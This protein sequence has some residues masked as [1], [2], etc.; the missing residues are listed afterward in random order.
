M[1]SRQR[2]FCMTQDLLLRRRLSI[3][4]Y[5]TTAASSCCGAA[6]C[7]SAQYSVRACACA[8]GVA[9]RTDAARSRVDRFMKPEAILAIHRPLP[10]I[11]LSPSIN[12]SSQ[13]F[14]EPFR[15]AGVR[16]QLKIAKIK[17]RLLLLSP[18]TPA[19]LCLCS[20]VE[21]KRGP[22]DRRL[23]AAQENLEGVSSL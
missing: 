10:L 1:A 18:P 4:A 12:P 9:G 23:Y 7:L 6:L 2:P 17:M 19:R 3:Q 20:L 21:P 8:C 22:R 13:L 5:C 14:A 15:F 11:R 16:R